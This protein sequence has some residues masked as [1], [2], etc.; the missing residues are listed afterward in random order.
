[1]NSLASNDDLAQCLNVHSVTK[2]MNHDHGSVQTKR[3]LSVLPA[4]KCDK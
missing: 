3:S 2:I 4:P 1:M